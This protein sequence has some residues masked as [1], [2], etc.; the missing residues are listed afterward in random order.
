[1]Q[2]DLEAGAG[3]AAVALHLGENPVARR[4]D[5]ARRVVLARERVA[6]AERYELAD[7]GLDAPGV[8]LAE[9]G[10]HLRVAA[11]GGAA[12][13]AVAR[14]RRPTPSRAALRGGRLRRQELAEEKG[15]HG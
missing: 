15:D 14:G 12:G 13:V 8:D 5:A 4:A 11:R 2:L 9:H 10:G 3:V 7:V 6:R 1:L